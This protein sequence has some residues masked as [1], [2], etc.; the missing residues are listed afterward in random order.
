MNEQSLTHDLK[1]EKDVCMNQTP[2]GETFNTPNPHLHSDEM[3][4]V[5]RVAFLEE[6]IAELED[7]C[8][9]ID[10]AHEIDEAM[11]KRLERF[12]IVDLLDPFVITNKLVVLL[13]DSIEEW[14]QLKN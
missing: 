6:Q 11:K 12:H 1:D 7:I 14:Q 13:E 4:R 5:A 3:H 2:I 8:Q 10:P 9:H